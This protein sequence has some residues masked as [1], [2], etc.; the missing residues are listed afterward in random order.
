MIEEFSV[1]FERGLNIIT[2]ETGAGKSIV[3]G[4]F[5]LLIGDRADSDALRAGTEKAI[6]EAD[7]D[8]SGN[9]SL[10]EFLSS[11]SIE[12]ENDTLFIR[13]EVSKK[14]SSRG[15]VNDSPVGAQILRELSE[16]LVDLHGQHEHQS[17]LHAKNHIRMLDEYAGLTP[18]VEEYRKQ[19]SAMLSL[20]REI[21][22]LKQRKTRLLEEHDLF[23][24]Q[25]QEILSVDPA[26]DEDEAIE[27]K[28]RV[29]E[30][31]EE[32]R[33]AAAEIHA[34]LYEDEGSAAEKLGIIKEQLT[35]LAEIDSSLSEPLAEAKSALAIVTELSKWMSKY[36]E[37]IELDPEELATLR[38]R[39]QQLQ[40]LKKKFGGTLNA[41]LE[42]KKELGSKLSFEDEFEIE[43]SGKEK[44][45]ELLRT[46]S[47]QIAATLSKS[48]IEQSLKLEPQIVGILA[49]LGI[50]RAQFRVDISRVAADESDTRS[51]KIEGKRFLANSRGVDN[52]EFFIS[53][54]AG[55][56][57][58]PLAR[59][60]SGGEISRIMLA[61]KTVLAKTDKLP[62]LIFDEID[63]GISGRIAQRVGRAMKSLSADHQIIAITHLAQ[64]A[65]CADAHYLA[66]KTTKNG[67]TSSQLRRLTDFEHTQE[68]ARLISGDL[69]TE[70]SLENARTL[71]SE[72][73]SS[74]KKHAQTRKKQ[75]QVIA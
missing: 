33:T 41:V 24:F 36:S 32:L 48:R 40:R 56:E 4:A 39:A 64:I 63:I 35:N 37:R 70:S 68:V 13:R 38:H 15:F 1:S 6:V 54:N 30:N 62:L 43:L 9:P 44:E 11:Q 53:T 42:K 55:E 74:E 49:D 61:L 18:Q 34:T 23:A 26:M 29:L 72:A 10:H 28:L 57:P 46:K 69:V 21:E 16:F 7:F 60:A 19:H 52:I 71:I 5:G 51:L 50:E 45:V 66:E 14:G 67:I 27:E 3:L 12:F 22:E 25:L 75:A 17:L 65:A 59:V 20:T 58:K 8:I 31:A 47:V 2:G 73:N